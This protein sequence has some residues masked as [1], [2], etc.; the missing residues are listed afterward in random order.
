MI[1]VLVSVLATA[2]L[3]ALGLGMYVSEAMLRMEYED[4]LRKSFVKAYQ[5]LPKVVLQKMLEMK[6]VDKIKKEA[7][8]V[9]L[10]KTKEEKERSFS[11]EALFEAYEALP[12]AVLQEVL[13]IN[14]LSKLEKKIAKDL[15]EKIKEEEEATD[16]HLREL[17]FL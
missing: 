15:L 4:M 12:K 7:A 1:S 8:S 13:K 6:D 9:L 11:K 2:V 3:A 16:K 14:Q 17:G 5:P 10:Y